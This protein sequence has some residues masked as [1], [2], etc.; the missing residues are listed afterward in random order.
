[1]SGDEVELLSM[2]AIRK[3]FE[4]NVVLKGVTFHLLPG[5]VH[6]LVGENGAGKSTLVNILAGVHQPDSGTIRLHGRNLTIP[7]RKSCPATR[8]CDRFPRTQ[9]VWAA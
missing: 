2:G 1:M 6:A 7:D 5:E 9:F 8:Y 3:S 4:G